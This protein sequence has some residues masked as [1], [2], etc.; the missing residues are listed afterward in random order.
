[1][2]HGVICEKNYAGLSLSVDESPG[3]SV[4]KQHS[5][6]F[7]GSGFEGRGWDIVV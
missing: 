7:C 4:V 1:M 3:S 5:L 2:R 6:V